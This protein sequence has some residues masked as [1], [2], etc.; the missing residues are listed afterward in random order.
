MRTWRKAGL[1]EHIHGALRE[2]ARLRAGR[3]AER[4]Y[5]R[6]SVD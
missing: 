4:V 6:L 3:E 2:R 1:W 5:H